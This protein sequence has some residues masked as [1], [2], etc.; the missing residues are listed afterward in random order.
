[1]CLHPHCSVQVS[2]QR[3]QGLA[4]NAES[5]ASLGCISS[6]HFS[7]STGES[8]SGSSLKIMDSSEFYRN[9]QEFYR[10]ST[11]FSGILQEST[12][13]NSTGIS[14]VRAHQKPLEG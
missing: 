11:G 9:L 4:G 6:L 12:E 7:G 2:G 14:N 3:H 8:W 5:R 13:S 10:N 1:M